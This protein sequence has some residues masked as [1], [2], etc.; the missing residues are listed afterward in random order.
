MINYNNKTLN[1]LIN[2]IDRRTTSHTYIHAHI[3]ISNDQ[4]TTQQQQQKTT[5]ADK[6]CYISN[7]YIFERKII[8]IKSNQIYQI[9]KQ[10]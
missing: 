1:I 8:I 3:S 6:T 9:N 2:F 7:I 5:T 4:K 10:S